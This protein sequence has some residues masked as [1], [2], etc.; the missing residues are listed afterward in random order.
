MNTP[1][2]IDK[3]L[4]NHVGTWN[5]KQERELRKLL[6]QAKEETR[7]ECADAY[8]DKVRDYRGDIAPCFDEYIEAI[9]NA[10]KD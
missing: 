1:D 9:L 7:R 3:F 4:K 6:E 2:E 8:M 10:G 5:N